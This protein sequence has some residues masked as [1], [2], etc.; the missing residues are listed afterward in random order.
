MC[1][2]MAAFTPCS[3]WTWKNDPKRFVLLGLA[4]A[5]CGPG[6]ITLGLARR[7]AP[8]ETVGIDIED[9]QLGNARE[10]AEREGLDLEFRTAIAYEL[11]FP[12]QPFDAHS[13]ML[14]SNTS[15]T[16]VRRLRNYAES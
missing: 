7:M 8:G 12:D 15:A 4:A 5:G 2:G 3:R 1:N 11:P 10:E 9:S 13:L 14:C 16:Q 6:T